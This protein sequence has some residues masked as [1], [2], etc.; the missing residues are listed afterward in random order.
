MLDS[1]RPFPGSM[2]AR[3]ST[4][5]RP[6]IPMLPPGTERYR[7]PGQGSVVVPV[8]AGD[9]IQLRD[10]EGKQAC[11]T[12]FAGTDGR[13][14]G[15]AL[16]NKA[17]VRCDGL[18]AILKDDSESAERSK[19]TLARRNIDL[20]KAVGVRI[21]GQ[22]SRPGE[23]AVLQVSRDG[24]IIVAA[25]GNRMSPEGQDT[26]TPIE[27]IIRRTR[28]RRPGEERLPEPLRDPL[29]DLRIKAATASAYF[30]KAGEFIQVIDISGRQ[31]TDFQAFAARKL[32]LG[33]TWLSMLP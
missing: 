17:P 15:R 7:V 20:S 10:M 8:E 27:L 12:A 31:C 33:K 23:T 2:K 21:F 11:E 22:A 28:V 9:E 16:G 14:D 5:L 13:F 32:D 18:L 30:V 26:S 4:I 1:A 25:P 29:F 6:G 24:I 19:A 3:P